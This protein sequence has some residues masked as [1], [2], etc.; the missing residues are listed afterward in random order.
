MRLEI[1][2]MT[3]LNALRICNKIEELKVKQNI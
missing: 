1:K 2:V 3:F